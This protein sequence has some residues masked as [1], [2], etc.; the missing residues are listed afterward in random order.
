MVANNRHKNTLT[1]TVCSRFW[2]KKVELKSQRRRILYVELS[3]QIPYDQRQSV[4]TKLHSKFAINSS[5]LGSINHLQLYPNSALLELIWYKES[6]RNVIAIP[7]ILLSKFCHVNRP[8][9]S[10]C[11]ACFVMLN[12]RRMKWECMRTMGEMIKLTKL[13]YLLFHKHSMRPKFNV[14]N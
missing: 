6:Q 3:P 2:Q 13:H 7:Y 10:I 9:N 5:I 14:N 11:F 8:G 4:Q 1:N 12:F